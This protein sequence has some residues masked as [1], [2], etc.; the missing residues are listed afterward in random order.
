MLTNLRWPFGCVLAATCFLIGLAPAIAAGFERPNVVL[1]LLDNVGQEWFGCYGSEERCTP[2]ID[3]LATEGVRVENCYTPPVCGPSRTVLLTGRYPHTTGFRLHHDAALYGG[4]GLQPERDVVFPRLLR[5]AGYSTAIAGKWQINNLYDEPGILERHGF[6]ESLVWPGSIDRD[7][8]TSE[9]CATFR[10]I[11]RRE[12]YDDAVAFNRHIESRYWSPVFFRNGR[13]E[14]LPEKFGPDVAKEFALD[15]LR[16]RRNGP[17]FLYL[18][19]VLTHGQSFTENV[20]ATPSNRDAG[21]PHHEMFADMLRYADAIVGEI[22]TEIESLGLKKNTIIIVA[23]D[24][25]TEKGLTAR[26]NGRSVRGDLYG[27]SEAGGNVALLFYAPAQIPGGRVLP[28][29]DFTDIY[30]TICD[31]TGAPPLDRYRP[32][33]ISLAPYLRGASVAGP[34][35][36]ILNEY[37]DVRVVRNERYKLYSDGR[38]FDVIADPLEERNLAGQL[39]SSLVS[40]RLR[41]QSVLDSLPRNTPPPFRLLSLSAFRIRAENRGD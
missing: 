8:I 34:R 1:I 38:F 21:R 2:T 27:L 24:N 20:V 41:L 22:V 18:P 39:A 35:N 4:G 29:A 15:F 10:D 26:R 40:A 32:D 19:M 11:V 7:Q 16:R 33:G 17:F 37:H 6:Q 5:E 36:W 14:V 12:A 9:Q 13:R 3:R 31:F 28:L 23:S 30:P 25:G